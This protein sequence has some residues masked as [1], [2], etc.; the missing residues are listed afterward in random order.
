MKP[1]S[2]PPFSGARAGVPLAI[3]LSQAGRAEVCRRAKLFVLLSQL[4]K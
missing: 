1:M 4:M 2:R 3:V